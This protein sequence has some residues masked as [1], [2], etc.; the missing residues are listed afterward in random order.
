MAA[1]GA[2]C[3]LMAAPCPAQTEPPTVPLAYVRRLAVAPV[4]LATRPDAPLP[5]APSASNKRASARW[6]EQRKNR[7]AFVRLRAETLMRLEEALA[8]R[9][10]LVPGLSRIIPHAGDSA[11]TLWANS[12]PP[13]PE[14]PGRSAVGRNAE[15][16]PAP[17][18]AP[19]EQFARK[20]DADAALAVAIDRFGTHTGLEREVWLRLVAYVMP[21]DGEGPRGPFY[22][23]GWA[24]A[25]RKL[26]VK[27]FQKSDP[28]LAREA[29]AQAV[30]Q[31]IHTLQTGEES[32]F[33][34]DVRAAAVPAVVPGAV[35]KRFEEKAETA[36]VPLPALVRQS[37]VLLLPALSPVATLLDMDDTQAAL[38]ALRLTP[39]AFWLP[40]GRPSIETARTLGERLRAD[41]VFVSRLNSLELTERA[42]TVLDAGQPRN[43]VERRA[44]A[45][46]QATLIRAVDG[47][48]LWS[49]RAV[50]T[51]TVRTNY[52]RHK[53]RLL[54]DEQCAVDAART[55]FIYLR[56][57]L[58]EYKRRHE[59]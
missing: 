3:A 52:V 15:G 35:E 38:R 50:G 22:T 40:G 59:R 56:L 20:A 55:A 58:E 9:L 51:A 14:L 21:V 45:E 36:R 2:L 37:G 23:F 18:P 8:A 12:L 47:R 24:R 54:T 4:A 11:P 17:L 7:E 34:R 16:P 19:L 5:S 30:R 25:G 29:A 1:F 57:S 31:L 33:A 28:R 10:S 27:G 48:V 44:E 43:G 13:R 49:D 26:F 53:P 46:A 32:P 41:Y 42:I 6:Q 39:E